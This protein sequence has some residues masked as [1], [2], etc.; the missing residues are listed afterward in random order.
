MFVWVLK[1]R[2][3]VMLQHRQR[4]EM[5]Q[6]APERSCIVSTCAMLTLWQP[7]PLPLNMLPAWWLKEG[8]DD[9]CQQQEKGRAANFK[10]P[11]YRQNCSG[12]WHMLWR[13]ISSVCRLKCIIRTRLRAKHLQCLLKTSLMFKILWSSETQKYSPAVISSL[14]REEDTYRLWEHVGHFSPLPTSRRDSLACFS[15]FT[16]WGES[17]QTN[18]SSRDMAQRLYRRRYVCRSGQGAGSLCR[19]RERGGEWFMWVHLWGC[20]A[21]RYWMGFFFEKQTNT[22]YISL[23]CLEKLNPPAS[24]SHLHSFF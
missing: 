22:I 2:S 12:C 9:E 18:S 21:L 1:I 16:S 19:G 24:H 17:P 7:T 8:D 14:Q 6:S 5:G 4:K 20:L 11:P 13:Q 3:P 15:W 10:M 23:N